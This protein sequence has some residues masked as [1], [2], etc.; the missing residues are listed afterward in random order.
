MYSVWID[1]KVG[2]FS[3]TL[4]S[5]LGP[6]PSYDMHSLYDALIVHGLSLFRIILKDANKLFVDLFIPVGHN[7]IVW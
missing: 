6:F 1:V 4:I 5:W 2:F 7:V 3:W